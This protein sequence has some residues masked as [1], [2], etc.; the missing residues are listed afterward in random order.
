MH[1]DYLRFKHKSLISISAPRDV[2]RKS[3]EFTND[4]VT[5]GE[6]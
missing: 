5:V 1:I 4:S 3:I 6:H 2:S